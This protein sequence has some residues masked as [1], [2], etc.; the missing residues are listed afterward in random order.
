ML[1]LRLFFSGENVFGFLRIEHAIHCVFFVNMFRLIHRRRVR[2][3]ERQDRA[4]PWRRS[5]GRPGCVS[6]EVIAQ[7]KLDWRARYTTF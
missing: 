6:H 2:L 7:R 1:F 4:L 5:F 3:V